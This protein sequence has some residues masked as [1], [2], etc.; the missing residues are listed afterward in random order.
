MWVGKEAR[1]E[2]SK[3]GLKGAGKKA[4][5]YRFERWLIKRVER[6]LERRLSNGVL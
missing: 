4:V 2:A 3:G 5:R 1:K 6:G